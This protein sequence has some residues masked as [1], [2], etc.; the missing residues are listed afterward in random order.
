ML[1]IVGFIV[2]LGAVLG[3][4]VMAGGALGVMVQPSEFVVIF[5]AALGSLLVS[6]PARVITAILT[7][8]KDALTG[9]GQPR[10]I[11]RNCSPCS[12]RFPRSSSNWGRWGWKRT[13][14]TRRR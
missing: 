6:T 4:F 8:L 10:P 3:G 13:S 1:V 2:V 9:A 7:Q 14:K 12:S 11:T 5:G